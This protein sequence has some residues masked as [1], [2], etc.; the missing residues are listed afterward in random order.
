MVSEVKGPV[1]NEVDVWKNN[2]LGFRSF[3]GPNPKK[4]N[5]LEESL[6]ARKL[7]LVNRTK[8]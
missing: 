4:H 3:N 8:R 1:Y 7:G 6:D 2:V 5:E